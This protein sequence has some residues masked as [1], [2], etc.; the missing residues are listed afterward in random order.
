[1]ATPEVQAAYEKVVSAKAELLAAIRAGGPEPVDDWTLHDLNGAPVTLREL[2]G[3]HRD[4]L[5]VHNM[6]AFCSYCTLWADGFRGFTE[7]IER[8]CAFVLCSDDP[9]ATVKKHAESRGWNF[10]C[11]SGHESGF[12]HAMGYKTRDGKQLPGVSAFYKNADG[13]VSRISHSP[14]GPGDDFCAVWP[15]FD[16]L[17]DRHAGWTPK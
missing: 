3:E 1:M 2:F 8:R 7:H 12:A 15:L 17:K 5:V 14:F 10:R 16:L 11:V 9:P 6:G 13:S 4:L